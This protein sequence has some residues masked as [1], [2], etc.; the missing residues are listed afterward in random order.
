MQTS[1]PIRQDL[2]LRHDDDCG[3]I[4]QYSGNFY[5]AVIGGKRCLLKVARYAGTQ[6]KALLKR[7]YEMSCRLQHPF[8]LSPL[9][10]I[11]TP[12]GPA[13]V[14]EYVDGCT[15]TEFLKRK[16]SYPVRMR[17]LNEILDAV[18]YLHM[19]G[20]LH[21]D[22]KPDNVL[23]DS[24]GGHIKII[25][26]GLAENASEHLTRRLGGTPG[27]SA[28]EVMKGDTRIPSTAASDVYSL[29]RIIS[30]MF[31]HKFG[32]V[33]W[34]CLRESPE[35]RFQSVSAVRVA[36]RSADVA[37][38]GLLACLLCVMILSFVRGCD[39][40]P[41][42]QPEPPV[43]ES[44]RPRCDLSD[45]RFKVRKPTCDAN[46]MVNGE[47]GLML[48]FKMKISRSMDTTVRVVIPLFSA[49]AQPFPSV[50]RNY[51]YRSQ[52]AIIGE[53]DLSRK[54]QEVSFFIP[55]KSMPQLPDFPT[56]GL[57]RFSEWIGVLSYAAQFRVLL[58]D[59]N[60][61]AFYQSDMQEVRFDRIADYEMLYK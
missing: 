13:I 29:G 24:V 33:V 38:L 25:D 35:R 3:E 56:D 43:V 21:N 53:V 1:G 42:G 4:V 41:Q 11:D 23:I 34:K 6:E 26:F 14:M 59:E 57:S 44:V 52:G 19:K 46:A 45:V 28:P 55:F 31:P 30:D 12:K 27:Y 36:L 16:P 58:V 48:G 47:R 8:V 22:L 61:T 50:D 51:T 60:D 40:R 7:E 39:P 15:L 10:F 32:L 49:E 17:I 54:R 5:G 18:E 20:I 37:R 2:D 9:R